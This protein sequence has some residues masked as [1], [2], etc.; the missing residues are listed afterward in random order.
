[1]KKYFTEALLLTKSYNLNDFKLWIKWYKDI[2]K[3]DHIV[4]FDNE[5]SVDIEKICKQ[6]PEKITYNKV[7]GWPD[8]HAIYQNWV[9][10][11]SEA[12]WVFPVDDDEFLWISNK[13]EN[14]INKLIFSYQMKYEN[15]YRLSIGW[16]NL[17]PKTY[18]EK[19]NKSLIENAT[20][21]SHNACDFWQKGNT[22]VKTIVRTTRFTDYTKL[23]SIHNPSAFQR[24]TESIL[25]NGE[26]FKNFALKKPMDEYLKENPDII[27]FHYQWKSN[28]EWVE[29]CNKRV[30]AANKKFNKKH[31]DYYIKIY[32][33]KTEFKETNI[34]IELLRKFK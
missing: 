2:L 27:L 34:M 4:I 1:M 18:I 10:E 29:K 9:N 26:K 15:M 12:W 8:Q 22:F 30:S 13:Y 14:S 5:S 7:I 19:R 17:F 28:A 3:F 16:I 24:G 31:P 23:G 21:Y 33:K 25:F 6:F 20:A 32:D 11:K